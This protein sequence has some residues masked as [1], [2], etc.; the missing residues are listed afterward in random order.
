MTCSNPEVMSYRSSQVI[1][2]F[3]YIKSLRSAQ[4]KEFLYVKSLRRA[5]VKELRSAQVRS[6]RSA[7][8]RSFQSPKALGYCRFHCRVCVVPKST[9]SLRSAQVDLQFA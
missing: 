2:E 7:Q 6:L 9:W 1:K 8:V 4:V 5:Q 3:L